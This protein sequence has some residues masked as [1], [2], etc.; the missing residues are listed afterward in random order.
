MKRGEIFGFLGPNGAGKT[1]TINMLSGLLKPDKGEVFIN[2]K[3]INNSEI[4]KNKIGLC[5][6]ENIIW[7][8]LTCI[9]QL[10]FV[11]KIYGFSKKI[12]YRRGE[13]LLDF[14]GLIKKKKTIAQ[15]LSGGMKRR[16]CLALALIHDPDILILDEP[17]AGLDPQ[18]RILIRDF[19]KSLTRKKT[20]ILTTHNM[21]EA[22]RMSDR[23]AIIDFGKLLKL[24]TV[25]NLKKSIGDGDILRIVLDMD[26]ETSL[27]ALKD[28]LKNEK[29]SL[30]SI[31][32]RQEGVGTIIIKE[33]NIIEKVSEITDRIVKNG[34]II[35][36]TIMSENTLEDVFIALTGRNLRQ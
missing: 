15:Q 25:D 22:E 5:P 29:R 31:Y 16:L 10:E 18:S 32:D 8:K 20:I 14:L 7:P 4:V 3:K 27:N 24:D 33:K 17:E 12:S 1:T 23:V 11:G 2:G 30:K 19:I 34:F 26:K 6:Q 9:E 21:D 28:S 35:K 13:E 36:K